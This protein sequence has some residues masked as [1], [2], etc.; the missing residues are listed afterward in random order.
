V[1]TFGSGWG[2]AVDPLTNRY[3]S[4]NGF[5]GAVQVYDGA[6]NTQLANIP[7]GFIPGEFDLNPATNSIYVATQGG[8]GNDPIFVIN[9]AN[10]TVTLGPLGSGGVMAGV[11]VNPATGNIY[12]ERSNG[13]TR[14]FNSAGGFV[15]DLN[16]GIVAVNPVTNQVVAE[17]SSGNLDVLDGNTN[18]LLATIPGAG[19]GRIAVN[20]TL[21]RFYEADPF[22]NTVKV[23]DG[24]S[25]SVVG[26]FDLGAGVSPYLIAD[27]PAQ[28][29]LYVV[30]SISG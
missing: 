8:G 20:A 12:V 22:D 9:G 19:N 24:A 4:A 25:D 11:V 27:N 6:T 17:D 1:T 21:D 13:T 10:N 3:Y 18:A 30:A 23:I 29:L 28:N 15:T 16:L 7:V 5:G 26:S 14:E 2:A